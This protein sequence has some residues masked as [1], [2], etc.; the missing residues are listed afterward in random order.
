MSSVPF[1]L[2]RVLEGKIIMSGVLN[3]EFRTIFCPTKLYFKFHPGIVFGQYSD[4]RIH[5]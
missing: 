2:Y 5:K 3:N 1:H 4:A